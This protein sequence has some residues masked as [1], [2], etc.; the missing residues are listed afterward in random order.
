MYFIHYSF[1]K[2]I[3]YVWR[4]IKTNLI[5][6]KFTAPGQRPSVLKFLDPPLQSVAKKMPSKLHCCFGEKS[7][8]IFSFLISKC[9]Y[10]L[11]ERIEI[12]TNRL[13]TTASFFLHCL[14]FRQWL[15]SHASYAVALSDLKNLMTLSTTSN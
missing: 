7:D 14:I 15:Y 10:S 2:Q 5:P 9:K 4:G 11:R 6:K 1:Y 12:M 13:T 3:G 8:L